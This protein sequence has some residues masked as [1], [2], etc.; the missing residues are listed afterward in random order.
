MTGSDVIIITN[1]RL[2]NVQFHTGLGHCTRETGFRLLP[3][4]I[5]PVSLFAISNTLLARHRNDK[6][7]PFMHKRE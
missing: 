7:N 5:V 6:P 3:L 2:S 1:E 4:E